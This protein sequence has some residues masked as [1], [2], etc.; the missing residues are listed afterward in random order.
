MQ[1]KILELD[2]LL[3][4]LEL[5][6]TFAL[7]PWVQAFALA[8]TVASCLAF[9]GHSLAPCSLLF[10]GYLFFLVGFMVLALFWAWYHWSQASLPGSLN[11]LKVAFLQSSHPL[12]APLHLLHPSTLGKVGGW[13]A[14]ALWAAGL[15]MALAFTVAAGLAFGPGLVFALAL[16]LLE[17]HG[18]LPASG[19]LPFQSLPGT[20]PAAALAGLVATLWSWQG[21]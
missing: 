11:P 12:A 14:W 7:D 13:L 1:Q 5:G 10:G 18:H 6:N 17:Q 20:W 8:Q 16:A 4:V 21:H 9:G 15:F 19:K 2:N 3:L